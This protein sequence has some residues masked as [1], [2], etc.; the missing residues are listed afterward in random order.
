MKATQARNPKL[1]GGYARPN[2]NPETIGSI[3][4]S[5]FIISFYRD[6]FEE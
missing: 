2:N 3:S 6:K 1:K 4:L 5:I